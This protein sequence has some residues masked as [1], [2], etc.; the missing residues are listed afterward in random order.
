MVVA[1]LV[2]RLLPIPE[3]RC[4]NP[5]IGKNCKNICLLSNV[6]WKDENKEKEAGDGLLFLKKNIDCRYL[7]YRKP[8][9]W[10][11][12]SYGGKVTI[13]R[14]ISRDFFLHTRRRL[15]IFN[16]RSTFW[17]RKSF[18]SWRTTTTI[19]FCNVYHKKNSSL[20]TVWPVANL[21]NILR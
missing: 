12:Q 16:F 15:K 4:L 9:F 3:V 1:Q 7:P 5:V 19:A 14:V 21:I 2:E 10:A 8:L 20:W 6:Y 17:R 11:W 13:C 18:V